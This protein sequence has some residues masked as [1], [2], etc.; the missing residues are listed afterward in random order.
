MIK[1]KDK[2]IEDTWLLDK[3]I[4]Y[5]ISKGY[6]GVSNYIDKHNVNDLKQIIKQLK[7]EQ[8]TEN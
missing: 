6:K 3:T 8:E 4:D 5:C 2:P 1:D 7:N